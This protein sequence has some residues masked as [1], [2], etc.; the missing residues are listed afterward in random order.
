MKIENHEDLH[1]KTHGYD[2]SYHHKK[3]K[4]LDSDSV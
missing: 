3:S 4:E 2:D 1:G